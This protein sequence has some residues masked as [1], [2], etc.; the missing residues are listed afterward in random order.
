MSLINRLVQPSLRWSGNRANNHRVCQSTSKPDAYHAKKETARVAAPLRAVSFSFS[1]LVKQYNI[2]SRSV[3]GVKKVPTGP[4]REPLYDRGDKTSAICN[5]YRRSKDIED[6]S[7]VALQ[8]LGRL[9]FHRVLMNIKR[10]L[11]R[12]FFLLRNVHVRSRNSRYA[13]ANCGRLVIGV[14]FP[15]GGFVGTWLQ[16]SDRI[17]NSCQL[18]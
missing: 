13:P 18:T 3:E 6:F 11:N 12:T 16:S 17:V 7:A 8:Y 14:A 5:W 10:R 15:V 2:F 4:K 1:L 9:L